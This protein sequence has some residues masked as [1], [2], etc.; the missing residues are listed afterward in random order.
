[1]KLTTSIIVLSAG[2]S[3]A[4]AI[5]EP[6]AMVFMLKGDVQPTVGEFDELDAGARFTL[7][8]GAEI[9]IIHY[10]G[11]E[12]IQL[13]GGEVQIRKTGVSHRDSRVTFRKKGDC[14]DTVK[15]VETDTKGAVVLMR[16]TGGDAAKP[17]R[18]GPRP[19][20]LLGGGG[21][22]GVNALNVFESGAK[23]ATVPLSGGRG[24]WPSGAPA[25]AAGTA[26]DVTLAGSGETTRGARILI[27]ANG[28]GL[29]VLR[30]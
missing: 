1:M 3:A 18:S 20:F 29:V 16:G 7:A 23:I 9:G 6:A 17:I 21:A 13:S 2:L 4:Q 10:R 11:C 19:R 5:A 12:E 25:L 27:E 15:L 8:P 14:P 24:A 30:P 26:Y 28:A 22:A